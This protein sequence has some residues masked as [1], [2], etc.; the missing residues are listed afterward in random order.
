MTNTNENHTNLPQMCFVANN[1][2]NVRY[3]LINYLIMF[4]QCTKSYHKMTKQKKELLYRTIIKATTHYW[5][6]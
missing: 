6:C 1:T 5:K 3:K 4:L 2:F